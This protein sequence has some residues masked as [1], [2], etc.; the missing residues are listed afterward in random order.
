MLCGLNKKKFVQFVNSCLPQAGVIFVFYTFIVV[1]RRK[2]RF[3]KVSFDLFKS[4][5]MY[6][7]LYDQGNFIGTVNSAQP[8][9]SGT[10]VGYPPS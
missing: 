3:S 5:S 7:F 9:R 4:M 10:L 8:A 6:S 1:S 2:R